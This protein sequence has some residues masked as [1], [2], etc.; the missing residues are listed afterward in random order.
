M[1][2]VYT[3]MGIPTKIKEEERKT[4]RN[5]EQHSGE[6]SREKRGK[7]EC[8][9]GTGEKMCIRDRLLTTRMKQISRI[10]YRVW[11]ALITKL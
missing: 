10:G 7:L 9:K 5:V 3:S 6:D 2:T 11:F 4:K 8:E 1:T